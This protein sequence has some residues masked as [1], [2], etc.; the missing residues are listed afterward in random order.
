MKDNL[1]PFFAVP[2]EITN[3]YSGSVPKFED[4]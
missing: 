2:D 4:K 3:L 1:T